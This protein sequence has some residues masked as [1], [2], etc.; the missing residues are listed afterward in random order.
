MTKKKEGTVPHAKY[1]ELKDFFL[2]E[3]ERRDKEI[4]R[5]KHDNEMVMRSALKQSERIVQ[6]ERHAEKL[7]RRLRKEKNSGI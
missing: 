4:D 3:I 6:W 7:E 2:K 1:E 5:L